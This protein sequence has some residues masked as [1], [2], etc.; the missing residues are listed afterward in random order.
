[1]TVQCN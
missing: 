1:M